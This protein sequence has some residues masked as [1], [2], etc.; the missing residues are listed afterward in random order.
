MFAE[1]L[2]L[3]AGCLGLLRAGR[4]VASRLLL[5]G[6]I[7][8]R[9]GRLGWLPCASIPLRG[10][11]CLGWLQMLT[12]DPYKRLPNF[13]SSFLLIRI[14][15]A[16]KLT[17]KVQTRVFPRNLHPNR[18]DALPLRLH[19]SPPRQAAHAPTRHP[20]AAHQVATTA[21]LQ[22]ATA[23]DRCARRVTPQPDRTK[24]TRGGT[25]HEYCMP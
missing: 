1:S 11:G 18:Q 5:R 24:Q 10:A 8:F 22:A 23:S 7:S 20:S 12:L 17:R 6:A 19:H 14:Y 2:F 9:A 4:L 15:Y 13:A 3:G 21:R 25:F 16:A